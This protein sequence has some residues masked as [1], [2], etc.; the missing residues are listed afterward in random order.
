MLDLATIHAARIL[1]A[2]KALVDRRAKA[3][4]ALAEAEKTCRAE[5]EAA[6]VEYNQE[7]MGAS[8]EHAGQIEAR[9]A[10]YRA[11]LTQAE[12]AL[13]GEKSE[14][15]RPQKQERA[16]PTITIH[17]PG[18]PEHA[19]AIRRMDEEAQKLAG[20]LETDGAP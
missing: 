12:R 8:A 16:S 3:L 19:E 7:C 20:A 6:L 17:L 4:M 2:D 10:V 14:E 18:T 5:L 1:A 9:Q 15:E 13:N 11:T